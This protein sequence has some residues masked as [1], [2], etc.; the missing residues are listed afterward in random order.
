MAQLFAGGGVWSIT[1]SSLKPDRNS[2]SRTPC[3]GDYWTNRGEHSDAQITG[4]GESRALLSR[5]RGVTAGE[6]SELSAA[7]GGE[8]SSDQQAQAAGAAT[9]GLISRG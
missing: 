9:A 8:Y 7:A 6:A 1:A 5:A 2:L 4:A 3:A